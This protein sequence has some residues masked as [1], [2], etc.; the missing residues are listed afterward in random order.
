M[1]WPTTFNWELPIF[2]LL[3]VTAII[4]NHNPPAKFSQKNRFCGTN[5]ITNPGID[6]MCVVN[7][8]SK[9]CIQ[10]LLGF[11]CYNFHGPD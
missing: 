9:L 4:L 7:F 1:K 10:M 3:L 8:L 6:T 5:G 11:V 2:H